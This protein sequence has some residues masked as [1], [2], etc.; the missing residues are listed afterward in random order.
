[1]SW[2]TLLWNWRLESPKKSRFAKP[3]NQLVF[4]LNWLKA[5]LSVSE[6]M[7]PPDVRSEFPEV[8]LAIKV[9]HVSI[10]TC[11]FLMIYMNADPG[12]LEL[13]R[14]RDWYVL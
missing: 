9:L 2:R 5:S 10:Q 3:P 8:G 6:S 11:G 7:K 14:K 12:Y 13:L 1:M 4:V